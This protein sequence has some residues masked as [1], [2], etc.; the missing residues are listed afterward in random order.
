M[1]GALRAALRGRAPR[2]EPGIGQFAGNWNPQSLSAT[3]AAEQ[4]DTMTGP[5][6]VR[7]GGGRGGRVYRGTGW[8][9]QVYAQVQGSPASDAV[10]DA[11]PS[12]VSPRRSVG[13]FRGTPTSIGFNAPEG[14]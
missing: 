2:G 13:G 3:V 11:L 7:L 5:A 1:L 14:D 8:A 10:L 6:G 4:L 9:P 12:K